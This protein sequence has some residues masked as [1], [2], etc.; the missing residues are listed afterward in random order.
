M[1]HLP[2]LRSFR[3][4]S[5]KP[6]TRGRRPA[7]RR[8]EI[9]RLEDR[10]VPSV[11]KS[12]IDINFD[13]VNANA[14][15][16][17]ATA[18]LA[19]YGITLGG[20]T[21]GTTLDVLSDRY[22][23]GGRATV[24]PSPP[25]VLMQA[26]SNLPVSFTL[27]FPTPLDSFGF[28]R[29]ELLAVT[30]SGI[31]FPQWSAHAFNSQG[32]EVFTNT[33]PVGEPLFG[34]FSNV[35][36]RTFTIP[37]PGI[38]SVR[39]DSNNF[40]F[41]AF[42]AVLLDDFLLTTA[43]ADTTAPTTTASLGGPAL[44]GG[45]YTGP[46]QV[47]L[48]AT[49]PDDAPAALTTSYAID[50]GTVQM[51]AGP[52][53]VSGEGPHT[54]SYF[55]TDPAGNVEAT[56]SQT[57]TIA[58][59]PVVTLNAGLN[60]TE[61]QLLGGPVANFLDP[62]GAQNPS[63]YLATID[64][65][66]PNAPGADTAGTVSVSGGQLAV[67]GSHTYSEEGSYPVTVTVQED[68]AGQTPGL[69]GSATGTLTVADAG[70]VI[71]GPNG[72]GG[73]SG[74]SS[75]HS[76]TVGPSL[77]TPVQGAR[78]VAIGGLVYVVGGF[79]GQ[80]DVAS[81]E[82]FD[83]STGTWT[84]LPSMPATDSGDAGRYGGAAADLNGKLYVV[85]G[86]RT[87]PTTKQPVATSSVEIYDPTSQTWSAGTPMPIASADS[88]AGAIDGKLYVLTAS[89]GD[90]SLHGLFYVYDPAADSWTQLPDAPAV[91]ADPAA[92]VIGQVFY[93]A[94][95]FDA[96]GATSELDAY[97]TTAG[98]WSTLAPMPTARWGAAAATPNGQLGVVGGFTT[99]NTP[100]NVVEVYSPSNN[101]WKL[102][103]DGNQ[104]LPAALGDL[105]GAVV[106]NVVY[107]AGGSDGSGPVATVYTLDTG[108][109]NNQNNNPGGM[110]FQATEGSSI[111]PV[112]LATF[113]DLGGPEATGDYSAG[114][115]WGD[116]TGMDAGTIVANS[117]GSFSVVGSHAYAR[118]GAYGV[119]VQ[120][121][122]ENAAPP[123]SGNTGPGG[124]GP[125][126]PGN[127]GNPG[128]PGNISGPGPFIVGPN[129]AGISLGT[130]YSSVTLTEGTPSVPL[131]LTFSRYLST[132]SPGDF[133]ATID[134]GDNTGITG[135]TIASTPVG[136]GFSIGGNHQYA[137]EGSYTAVVQLTRIGIGQTTVDVPVTVTDAAL[138]LTPQFFSYTLGAS[139][140]PVV[141]A[142]FTD[143]GGPEA[144]SAYSAS[145]DWGDNSPATPAVVLSAGPNLFQIVGTP[146]YTGP[147]FHNVIAAVADDNGPPF[148]IS[149][150][151][152]VDSSNTNG[153]GP[154]GPG[155]G[156]SGPGNGL[157]VSTG[158]TVI[159]GDAPLTL[160]SLSPPSA[161]EGAGT[162]PVTVAT[163]QDANPLASPGDFTATILWGDGR[164]DAGG[165]TAN[166]DGTFSVT[167]SH[168][169]AEEA[170]G[171]PFQV[172]I[173]DAG[174]ANLTAGSSLDVAD[175]DLSLL[176]LTPPGP[177]E[178]VPTGSITVATFSDANPAAA[179]GDFTATITWGDG[180]T[181]VGQV[182][183]NGDGT[184][185][186][187]DAHTYGEEAR[188]LG[189]GV[190][191]ADAGGASVGST[192][193]VDVADPDLT[194]VSLTPPSPVEGT[195][196]G[197][198]T[199]ATFTDANP[200]AAAGDFSATITWGDGGSDP[201]QV[202]ANSDGSF[203]VLGSHTYAEEA[204]GLPFSVRIKDVG[205][206]TL[207]PGASVIVDDAPLTM[208]TFSPPT[209]TEGASTGSLVVATFSDADP[210]AAAGDYG[211]AIAWGDGSTTAGQVVANGDGTFSVLGSH[212]YAEE[213]QGLTFSVQVQ[214][215]GP[216][217]AITGSNASVNVADAPLSLASFTPPKAA[218]G[219]PTGNLVL[220]TF[221]DADPQGTAGDY[222]ATILW[223]DGATTVGGIAANPDGS[224]RVTGGHTY[225]AGGT[226]TF[227]VQVQDGGGATTG[228][229][230][231]ITVA[232]ATKTTVTASP[233]PSVWGQAV[234]FQAVVAPVGTGGTPVGAVTFLDG[235]T[236]LGTGTLQAAGG[237]DRAVFS[238]SA[239]AVGGHSITAVY[240]GDGTFTGSTSTTA[241][242]Q[243]VNAAAAGT[244]LTSS[245]NPSQAGQ[246][247]T[248]TATV[249]A[250][251]PG[252]GTPTGTVT[253]KDGTQV[254]GTGTLQVAG[255]VDKAS[256]STTALGPGGHTITAVYGGDADFQT[257]TSA[258]LTQTVIYPTATTLSPARPAPA[259]Y[260]QAVTFTA[261]VSTVPATTP[262]TGVVTFLLDGTTSLAIRNLV[263]GQ[264]VFT[265]TTLPA[266]THTI[267]AAYGGPVNFLTSTSAPVTQVITPA[268][269]HAALSPANPA[270][271]VYG[272]PATFT[273][274]VSNT[275]SAAMPSGTVTFLLD[276]T[277]GLGTRSLVGGQAVLA[278]VTLPGGSHTLTAVYAGSANFGAS[279]SPAVG[280]SVTSAATTT[281]VSPASP[282]PAVYGQAFTFTAKVSNTQTA[283][284]PVGSVTFTLDG[285]TNLGT[286]SLAA[287]QAVLTTGVLPSGTHTL[288]ATYTATA[289]FAGSTS[290]PVKLVIN[291]AATA[292]ALSP[293][294]VPA[295]PFGKAITLT[296]AVT[297]PGTTAPPLGTVTFYLDATPTSPGTTLGTGTL[298]GGAVIMSL[299]S[300]PKGKH[301]ITA[302]FNGT[303]DFLKSTSAALVVTIT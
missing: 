230:A 133:T 99:A 262:P 101:T 208:Q 134:W 259:A 14:A 176:T 107:L 116:G 10:T 217:G 273:A 11:S 257:S 13:G 214:D 45:T 205:G 111:G 155:P 240:G 44:G 238:T 30:Q 282:A 42:S 78:A 242:T 114:I 291:L 283:V 7:R 15:P 177:L 100:A 261:T 102:P 123:G 91:H 56:A 235:G 81:L 231:A 298:K 74:Q 38:T 187:I 215:G 113:S 296:A 150:S 248:F 188:G 122:H 146:P 163:F 36:A 43:A 94:G 301:T 161:I 209:A 276:G 59:P 130:S 271:L 278:G 227:S 89:T 212:T 239:L 65:G 225:T 175:A 269:T 267:T 5:R 69:S 90:G 82:S 178:G 153:T 219:V 246:A 157:V 144:I 297:A 79:N 184:F 233:N 173:Q 27:D 37:G 34:S 61:G 85:G 77:A 29:P 62:A 245:V 98:T 41:A 8:L 253:F 251:A 168:T 210:A 160:A 103:E 1:L 183:A 93:V 224:F 268:A 9:E 4:S 20:I 57:F 258:A 179:A 138:N 124:N 31:T 284:V 18:Y 19:G 120:I 108:G 197:L 290:A 71:D 218:V 172:V 207:S 25:N 300:I 115:D 252:A 170:Q 26:G 222:A 52:F 92:G 125:S 131:L 232:L 192:A 241:W 63:A 75:S 180:Q 148:S 16:V 137:Q 299:S 266:G 287:G 141:V 109:G 247:V 244:T 294:V 226:L 229:G 165:I 96:S 200:A 220:A 288:T 86:W 254:I 139:A 295:T 68:A 104:T 285:T 28:T 206:A 24:A 58:L 145:I 279:T 84:S 164:S 33:N 17:D 190:A 143:M 189:F 234:T 66:D 249:A 135:A 97:D 76:W 147:G 12:V 152:V 119:N 255:G 174:G 112:V 263:A 51:Y 48:S 128:G 126:G 154:G 303:G 162:G 237:V 47:T 6:Q 110:T 87:D 293:S 151:V 105:T 182:V 213:A 289:G 250:R 169:Y 132:D 40:N 142:T 22:I 281:V 35:P 23:Y 54:V 204:Q 117:D 49:D 280:Q 149:M 199:L 196:T 228:S 129:G 127:P 221:R 193:L 46:V 156:G 185:S 2:W 286:R 265:S 223:G 21:P 243:T 32:Q 73:S 39:F 191:I 202:A 270:P 198:V 264:A 158:D 277:T 292:I 67:T 159:V 118:A 167:G 70:L 256:F 121:S 302:I 272:Q 274:T 186:V 236:T 181:D 88:A 83:P 50:G 106:G 201:G 194:L 72:G 140:S 216:G 55:S 60:G 64:W 171:L 195:P 211:A 275:Q 136:G 80:A 203:S 166:S 95:G 260:G 53:T 3:S